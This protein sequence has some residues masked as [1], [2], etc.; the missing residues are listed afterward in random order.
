MAGEWV[1]RELA[2]EVGVSPKTVRTWVAAQGW[3]RGSRQWVLD[4][5]QAGLVREHFAET[6]RL[7]AP[8]ERAECGVEGCERPRVGRQDVCRIHY[9]RRARTGSTERSARGARQLEKTHCPAGHEYTP[10]N[11]YRFPSDNR[12]RRRCRACRIARSTAWKQRAAASNR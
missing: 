10:E 8:A 1:I 12:A 6:A 9:R 5:D 7:R 11:T 3:R 4:D 2:D